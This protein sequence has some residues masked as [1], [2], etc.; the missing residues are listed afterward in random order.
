MFCNLWLQSP[1]NRIK[2][3]MSQQVTV[4]EKGKQNKDFIPAVTTLWKNTKH[5]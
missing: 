1:I 5:Q 2:L 4:A 3:K